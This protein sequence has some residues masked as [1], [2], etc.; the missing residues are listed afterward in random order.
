MLDV[1]GADAV[2]E[3][4]EG[5]I[6]AGVAVAGGDHHARHHQPL[7]GGD[8]VLDALARIEDVEIFDAEIAR[9]VGEIIDLPRGVGI[10]H[11]ARTASSGRIDVIDHHQ[12]G[13][14]IPHLAPG[15]AQASKGLRAGIFVEHG[16]IDIEQHQ[17]VIVELPNHMRVDQSVVERAPGHSASQKKIWLAGRVQAGLLE[18]QCRLMI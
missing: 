15:G 10:R 6:G 12:R 9:I 3:R 14:R 18:I 13:G 5:A 2:A 17:P 16:A 1:G 8:D 7:L 4:A 11:L